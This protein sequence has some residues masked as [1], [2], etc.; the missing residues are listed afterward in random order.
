MRCFCRLLFVFCALAF[1]SG[2]ANA[3]AAL[4]AELQTGE[5]CSHEYHQGS[6][7]HHHHDADCAGCLACCLGACVSMPGLP[8]SSLSGLVPVTAMRIRYWLTSEM[9]PGHSSSPDLTPPRSSP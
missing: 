4:P 2:S 1:A 5:P 9:L 7:Q 3:H 8:P 6:P